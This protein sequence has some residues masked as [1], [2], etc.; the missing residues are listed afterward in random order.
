MAIDHQQISTRSGVEL[1]VEQK[2]DGEQMEILLRLKQGSA[3]VLHWGLRQQSKAEW[4]LPPQ[5]LWPAG[6]TAFG[7]HAAQTPFSGENQITIPLTS[8]HYTAMEFA[9]FFPEQRRWDNNGG[10]NYRVTMAQTQP[11]R[12][13][14][15]AAQALKEQIKDAEICFE[16]LYN[17]TGHGELAAAAFIKEKCYHIRFACD[18]DGPLL[19][20]WGVAQHFPGDWLLPPESARPPG[21]VVWQ[22]TTQTPFRQENDLNWLELVFEEAKVPLGIPFVLKQAETGDWLHDDQGKNFFVPLRPGP[23]PGAPMEA[24]SGIARTISQVE[25]GTQSWTLMHRFNLCYDLLQSARHN[26][27]ALAMLF[28]WLRYSAL[29]Q[30]TWQR[31]YNTKPRELSHAEE[32]LTFKMAELYCE[33]PE[34]RPLMRLM[35]T[36]VGRGGEGQRVRDEI[37]NIMH[38]HRIK[39]VAGHFLEEWHQKLHN[40]TTPDDI[41]ICEA[42]LG[43]LHSNGD[44]NIYFEILKAG[45]VT[46]E[47]LENF[48]RPI[49]SEPDFQ[50][51]LKDALI[52]DFEN[53]L[54][55]LKSVH[56]GTDLE[57]ALGSAQGHLDGDTRRL[58][59]GIW[60]RR[61]DPHF[62]LLDRVG[63]ITETRRR[64]A[65]LLQSRPDVRDLLFL[66]L[67]FEQYLRGTIEQNIHLKLSGDQWV[68]LIGWVVENLNLSQADAEMELCF[69]HWERLKALPR[70]GPDWSL[71]AKSVLDRIS[72]SLSRWID[73]TYQLLQPKAELLGRA[74]NADNWTV[75]LFSEEVV[76]GNSL[77]FALSM[78]LHHLEPILRKAAQL[79]NWQIISRGKGSG[80]VEVVENLRSI[81]GKTFEK[82]TIIIADRV[83]GDEEIPERVTAVIAPDVT[84]VVSHVAVRARNANLLFAS[85]FD[86]EVFS[87]LKALRG[88]HLELTLTPAGDVHYQETAA[89]TARVEARKQT[90]IPTLKKPPFKAYAIALADFNDNV[91]GKKSLNQ[92]VLKEKLPAWIHQPKSVALPFGVSEKVMGLP[93]NKTVAETS[94]RLIS[95]IPSDRPKTLEALRGEMLKLN[96][97]AELK[98]QLQSVMAKA[99]LSWPENWDE[100]WMRIKQVWASKWNERAYLSRRAMGIPDESLYMA[101][102][103]QEV[104]EAEYAFVI[105]TVNPLNGNRDE[106]FAEVVLGLG[107][108][109]VGNFPGRALSF[110]CNKKTRQTNVLSYPGKSVGLYGSGLIFRSDSNGEDLAGYAGAGLYESVLLHPPREAVLDYSREPLVWQSDFRKELLDTITRV[111]LELER[112][113]K[114]PQDVEGVMTKGKYYVVQT[115]PQMQA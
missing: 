55:I 21:T 48:E 113:L 106:L 56:A 36:T 80:T 18:V 62:S 71:H 68:E 79:G 63:Q 60:D 41:V 78:L 57:T 29:R 72:R 49:R 30:L 14:P 4:Q 53:F 99:N 59:F 35:L 108:T 111:G 6:T 8:P 40:N 88:R 39:E 7:Q 33:Q 90:A 12:R 9:L 50:G 70:F 2:A 95:L 54:R 22:S 89:G 3:C 31:N 38:R 25:M 83:M 110:V 51:W 42:Y 11:V 64:L 91:V 87:Q 32:R 76:R 10:K 94:A 37:L 44:R 47:R 103:V 24:L 67:A 109:L 77:G 43:F 97:P 13:G 86:S 112:L 81:Q 105:H 102:L 26:T 66:D 100:A 16:H 5:S 98:T 104:I 46:K 75:T 45:G 27:D 20:H 114:A 17:L 92:L 19:L 61:N 73:S 82:P 28:V 69:R 58:A 65:Q 85:C 84:D 107:E 101:V 74:F 23:K 96:A 115:R 15:S 34:Q 52:H 1:S 93:S